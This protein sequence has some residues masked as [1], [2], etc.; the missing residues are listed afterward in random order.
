VII[1]N[2]AKMKEREKEKAGN[3]ICKYC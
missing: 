3:L 2:M 1:I